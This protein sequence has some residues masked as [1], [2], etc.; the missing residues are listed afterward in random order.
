M[1]IQNVFHCVAAVLI[2]RCGVRPIVYVVTVRRDCS[3][4]VGKR[5]DETRDDALS[6]ETRKRQVASDTVYLKDAIVL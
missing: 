5:A 2:D 6:F 1:Q 4:E 3:C